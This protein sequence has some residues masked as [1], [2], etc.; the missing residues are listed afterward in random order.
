MIKKVVNPADRRTAKENGALDNGAIAKGRK[1]QKRWI[2]KMVMFLVKS[3]LAWSGSGSAFRF[4]LQSFRQRVFT[5]KG[6]NK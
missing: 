3:C 2:L 6:G 1:V 4:G 5:L